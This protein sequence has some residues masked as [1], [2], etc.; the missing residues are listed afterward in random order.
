MRRL[1]RRYTPLVLRLSDGNWW[2]LAQAPSTKRCPHC[3]SK[4]ITNCWTLAHLPKP[5]GEKASGT[6]SSAVSNLAVH[7][8]DGC[9]VT[10]SSKVG[11]ECYQ[12]CRA[13]GTKQQNRCPPLTILDLINNS[14]SDLTSHTGMPTSFPM[15]LLLL[16]QLSRHSPSMPTRMLTTCEPATA[17]RCFPSDFSV[18]ATPAPW[19]TIQYVSCTFVCVY[20]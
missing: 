10:A 6:P 16:S 8:G 3:V 12:G 7:D 11:R 9:A 19:S 18:L 15:R 2:K 14:T 4:A 13:N 5:K 17:C 20:Y 1:V